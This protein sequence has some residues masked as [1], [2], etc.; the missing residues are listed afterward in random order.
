MTTVKRDWE[1]PDLKTGIWKLETGNGTVG[2]MKHPPIILASVSPRR[3][4]LLRQIV[5]EFGIV[6]SFATELHDASMAPRRLCE[7]NAERKAWLVAERYPDHLVLGADT[8]VFLDDEPLGKPSDLDEARRMLG[9]LSGRIHMVVTGVCL[10]HRS[11]ARARL[12]SE[13]TYVR[14]RVL[15]TEEIE[16]YL[17]LVPVLDKAGSYA[18]QQEGHRIV[19][20]VEGSMSNVIGLPLESLRVALDQWGTAV[21]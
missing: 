17:K 20:R 19:D 1:L 8:L 7:V 11:G 6:D 10:I 18:I 2:A 9:R 5:P 3:R 21:A 14:F 12:F 15:S 13:A 16:E 4:D